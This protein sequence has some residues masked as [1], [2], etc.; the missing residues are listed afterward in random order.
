VAPLRTART[1]HWPRQLRS[2]AALRRWLPAG[3]PH[4]I[5][6]GGGLGALRG[7]KL[8]PRGTAVLEALALA[9][10]AASGSAAL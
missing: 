1:F 5:A 7:E 10:P 4:W 6:C 8:V 3:S 9:P 2:L